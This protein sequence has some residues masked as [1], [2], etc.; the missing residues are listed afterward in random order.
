MAPNPDAGPGSP[1]D[2]GFTATPESVDTTLAPLRRRIAEAYRADE[3]ETVRALL[4]EARLEPAALAATQ[5]YATRLAEAVRRERSQAGGVDALML[6]F[7]LDSREGVAL[8][9][10]AEALLRIPD[11][12]TRDRL[13]RDKIGR[14]DWRAHIGASPSLFVNAAAWGLLVTGR[15]VD[16]RSEGALEQALQSLLRKGGEPLIRKGVDLAMRLLGRQFVT[17]RTIDEALANAREREAKG[18]TYSFD[19]LGEAALT[20]ADAARYFDAYE[21]AIH[22]IGRASA[23]KGIAAGPGVSVKLSALH[24]R[25]SRAQRERVMRELG[26]KLS[27][28]ARLAKRYDIGF[29][30]D[31]EEADRLELS[32]DILAS[33]AADPALADWE[34]LGFV[35]QCY[36]KRA[37]PTIDWIVALARHYKRR[38][39]LRLV[40][41]AYWDSEIKR[42]QVDGMP[43]YPVFT[44][45]VHTD[46]AYLACAKAMLAAPDALYPQFASHNAFTIAAIRTLGGDTRYEFQ[47][48][49]GM[50][51]S[52]YDQL[53]VNG[54][55]DRA[56]RIYA[57]VGSHETL[58]AYLV[59]RLLENGANSSFV[60]RIVDPAVPIASLVE[61][62]VTIVERSGGA[63]HANLPLPAAMLPGRRNSSGVDLA[64]DAVLHALAAELAATP[65]QYE[66]GPLL[67]STASGAA[68]ATIVNPAD[69]TDTVGRV[70]TTTTEDVGRA[71]AAAL[72][73]GNEWSNTPVAERAACLERAAD[74]L[75][76][77]RAMFMTLAVREAGKTFGNAAAEVREAVDFLRYYAVEARSFEGTM[78][79]GPIVAISPWNFPLAIFT[80]QVAAALAAGN[81]VLAKPAEQT[82]LI[83]H[84]AVQALHEA[85]VPRAALQLLPGAGETI[86]AA[87]VAEPRIGGVLFTGS[88]DV[89]RAIYKQLGARDD[90]PVLVAETG[91]QN[92][93]IVDSSALPEQVVTDALVSAFDSAGQRC[94]ALRVLC[95]QDDIAPHV[96]AMLKGAMAELALGDPRRLATDVGPV[97]DADARAS[98]VAYVAS[99]RERGGPVLE[100]PLP[101]ECARGTFV[102]PTL[103]ELP[104]LD[105]LA[106]LKR[107]VFGPVLH[108][109]RWRRDELDALVDA[110]NATGYGLTH[111]IHTRIDETAAAILAR[112]RAGN[113]YVNRNMIG[114]VVGV[115]PFGG[116]GLSGT[117]PK[118]GGPLYLR[119]LVRGGARTRIPT[120][121]IALPGPTG[122]ANTLEWQPRGVVACIADDA[123]VLLT[124]TRAARAAGNAPLWIRN[125][126]AL[127]AK[128]RLEGERVVFADILDPKAVDAVLLDAAPERGKRIRAELA[129]APGPIVPVIVPEAD[130]D[131]DPARLVFE[132]TVTVNTA[133]AGGNAALLSL[134]EDR[135]AS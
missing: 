51:E 39:M 12:S 104:S 89:A 85:G 117:G 112:V 42:A 50:G 72:D 65:A 111:G 126:L 101:A 47:C 78:P 131:Y 75:E 90:D 38:L 46:V 14:G 128:D 115:Q 103:I 130:G 83:A 31:A 102:A 53:A 63:P 17:G 123:N 87:L 114:A 27:A 41:G 3:T 44:R 93:M 66:A 52:I 45:K 57:P 61:D 25:Y 88:T 4:A 95:L 108:V 70:V 67:A 62:P 81:P 92:A 48:L 10:V 134:S 99:M 71:I 106:A 94:S 9:C 7:S 54:K 60:N 105:A 77:R 124:Q 59:R 15:L 5:A 107:E 110:I 58:L 21:A 76:A 37:R 98:L 82:P 74:L 86:G 127:A 30:I 35:V 122:E 84:A 40:K 125:P 8:M 32:L 116:H 121:P 97:I 80:G 43:G 28:L 19:M 118:A 26:P 109:V 56:C 73:A 33:L 11:A 22:S 23:G 24:P 18:Y 91:G 6:E 113:V 13:I 119:R 2:F 68:A 20:A 36:Q 69:R 79:V 100:L 55:L 29:A 135:A 129:T 132:R 34:G 49:H 96:L 64:E 133:A 1:F 16:T 120:S